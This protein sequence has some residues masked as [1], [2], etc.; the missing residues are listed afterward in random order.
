MGYEI[1]TVK[2][3]RRCKPN[4]SQCES[5]R[6]ENFVFQG[7]N[8]MSF[9]KKVLFGFVLFNVVAITL[10][11]LNVQV[12]DRAIATDQ[13]MVAYGVAKPVAVAM[14]LISSGL[15]VMFLYVARG[16]L[17]LASLMNRKWH[18]RTR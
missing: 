8:I 2:S 12:P 15:V 18:E 14:T 13:E 9:H 6:H 5:D 7:F 17:K 3:L 4:Q 10:G 16:M 1:K 11:F